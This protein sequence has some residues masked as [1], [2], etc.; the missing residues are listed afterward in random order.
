MNATVRWI[1]IVVGFLVANALAMTFLIVASRTSQAQVIPDYYEKA[2]RFDETL[3]EQ[4][5]SRALGWKV[6]IEATPGTL[7]VDAKDA[8]GAS[9]ADASVELTLVPRAHADRSQR[10][11]LAPNGSQY[12]GAV[13]AAPG[14]HDATIVIVHAGRRFSQQVLVELP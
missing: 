1:M 7:I 13:T 6:D 10:I 3:A 8:N 5:H 4:A 2:A 11:A 14:L 12:R 9:L